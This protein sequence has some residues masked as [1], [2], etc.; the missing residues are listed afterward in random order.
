MNTIRNQF[1]RPSDLS[2]ERRASQ[3]MSVSL[4]LIGTPLALLGVL[5]RQGLML[6]LGAIAVYA[7]V[8]LLGPGQREPE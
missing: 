3:L 4:L 5:E 7:A 8:S 2:A 1:N 6:G